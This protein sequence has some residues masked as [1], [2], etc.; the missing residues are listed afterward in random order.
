[1]VA[2][3]CLAGAIY[4]TWGLWLSPNDRVVLHNQGDQALFEWLLTYQTHA[5]THLHNPLWT[6]LLNAPMGVN[7]AVNT[8]MVVVGTVVSPITLLFGPS[9]AFV[10]VLTLNLALSPYAW[11]WALSRF[12]TRTR[13]A[14]IMGGLFCGFAP[15]IVSHANAHLNFTAQYLVPIIIWRVAKLREPGH[16]IR[17]GLILA[18]LVAID[19]SVGAEML[20]FVAMAC[21][22][23]LFFWTVGNWEQAKSE[24]S[25]FLRGLGVAGA[26]GLTLLAYPLWLQFAGPQRYHGI[27]FD[28][29]VHSEDLA[30]FAGFSY[31]SLARLAGLW[32]QNWAAN[33][34]EETAFFGPLLVVLS[35]L[36]VVRLWR[37][38]EIRALALTGLVFGILSLGPR[39]RFDGVV[40]YRIRLPFVLLWHLPVFDTALPERLVLV[41]IPIVAVLLAV[42]LDRA[43]LLAP[44]WRAIWVAGL[45]L[46]LLPLVPLPIPT[47]HRQPVPQFF[48]DGTWRRY[49]HDGQTLMAIPPASDYLPDGQRWQTATNFAFA[50][51]SGFFLGPGGRDG[52]SRIG[53]VPR[54]TARL[55]TNV[56]MLGQLPLISDY[57]RQQARID[58][59]YWHATIIVMSDGGDGSRWTPN[60]GLLLQAATGLFG[61]PQRVEDVWVWRV[62]DIPPA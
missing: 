1:M 51:P 32:R 26:A 47:T 48:T 11:Y 23:Y 49:L 35:V 41:I 12:V 4:L 27:G 5:L 15:G 18:V 44:R 37:R 52:R 53:P 40:H 30:S 7:L 13:A 3:V 61:T 56:A 16:A 2:L 10:T 57:D 24:A 9:I 29:I 42:G 54:P 17:N 39:L 25:V 55:L 6:T 62:A 46:A 58:L 19:Y 31:L 59:A 34:T 20:L 8:S 60:R 43:L 38:A 36:V 21:A 28:Q 50:I 14:A 33:Y 22:V 45:A